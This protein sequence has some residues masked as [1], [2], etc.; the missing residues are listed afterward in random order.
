MGNVLEIENNIKILGNYMPSNY[1]ASRVV[2]PLGV[3]PCVKENHGTVTAILELENKCTDVIINDRGF[4]DKTPQISRDDICPTLRAETHGY[5]C[6]NIIEIEKLGF[7]DNGTGQHQSNTVIGI[8]GVSPALTTL[9][10]GTQQIKLL[11]GEYSGKVISC[12]MR[13]RYDENGK[14]NQHLEPND[15]F[16]NCITSVEKDSM[17]LEVQDKGR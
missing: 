14:V 5:G 4:S 9:Q 15:E 3:A 1:D 16:A 17:V 2:D 6:G 7:M 11:E 10:G 12:A 8:N 13:G